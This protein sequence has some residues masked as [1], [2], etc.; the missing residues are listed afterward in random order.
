MRSAAV[1]GRRRRGR[2][3]PRSRSR[4]PR[5]CAPPSRRRRLAR[6]AAGGRCR[7]A[8][9]RRRRDRRGGPLR[10]HR[11]LA[12]LVPARVDAVGRPRGAGPDRQRRRRRDRGRVPARRGQGLPLRARRLLGHR[13][14][15]RPDP[16][17][18]ALDGARRGGRDR[19]R[20]RGHRR[21]AVR[22]RPEG[23]HGGLRR[24]RFD[25]GACPRTVREG[26]HTSLFEI[27]ERRG[28][29]RLSSGVW[30]DALAA[31]TSSQTTSSTTRWPRWAPASRRP[32][33]CSTSTRS[34]SAAGW[35]ALR[36]ALADRL[37]REM[38]PHLFVSDR[39]PPVLVAAL[40]D[41]GGAVG[42]ALGSPD[43]RALSQSESHRCTVRRAVVC[44]SR[45]AVNAE[46]GASPDTLRVR[47]GDGR[48]A[49]SRG[50]LQ[51]AV[52]AA[53]AALPRGELHAVR[54]VP[55]RGR[56]GRSPAAWLQGVEPGAR[57]R[58]SNAGQR[59]RHDRAAPADRHRAACR[60]SAACSPR[61]TPPSQRVT[62]R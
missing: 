19:P 40:G 23:L 42:A 15:R 44:V 18:P 14:R 6:P 47:S 50:W 13:R 21:A 54:S 22:L 8:G 9:R 12:R 41:L 11:R 31:G 25:G 55:S 46:D 53:L 36:A 32:T 51:I 58:R 57:P 3:R 43:P 62:R 52:A 29:D 26:H 7:R 10:E 4:W 16:E 38:L 34:S 30:A 17:R 45:R 39:P 24:P 56:N 5:R 49:P 60:A 37:A 2:A 61:R 20:R 48:I 27:M 28:K 35:N 1:R 33:T 59:R